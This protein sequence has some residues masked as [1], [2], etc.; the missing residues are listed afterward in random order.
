MVG[1]TE[2]MRMQG[3]GWMAP[4]GW[5]RVDGAGWMVQG[6]GVSS[7]G[8]KGVREEVCLTWYSLIQKGRRIAKSTR[9]ITEPRVNLSG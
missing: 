4:N 5:C 6:G 8:H 1:A 3:A 7:E 9:A 2:D